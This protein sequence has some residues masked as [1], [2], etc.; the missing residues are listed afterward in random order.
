MVR[1]VKEG[2]HPLLHSKRKVSQRIWRMGVI[3]VWHQQS[4]FKYLK[5]CCVEKDLYF[6]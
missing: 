3:L 1:K 4:L 2:K 5:D 6:L